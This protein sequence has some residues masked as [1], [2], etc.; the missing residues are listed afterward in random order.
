MFT[1]LFCVHFKNSKNYNMMYKY[2]IYKLKIV[3]LSLL[4]LY[5]SVTVIVYYGR[6]KYV[7]NFQYFT[8]YWTEVNTK[9]N[10]LAKS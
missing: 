8:V 6:N 4:F 10:I 3:A 7:N 1:Y 2:W 5:T 9:I